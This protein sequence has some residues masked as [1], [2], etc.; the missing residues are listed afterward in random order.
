MGGWWGKVQLLWPAILVFVR[1]ERR[2]SGA[3]K[4]LDV[5]DWR[6]GEGSGGRCLWLDCAS[7]GVDRSP[8]VCP[9]TTSCFPSFFTTT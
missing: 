6:E 1:G 2:V 5:G 4:W 3:V 7:L 8:E 9:P